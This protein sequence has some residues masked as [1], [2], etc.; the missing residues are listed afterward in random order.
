[1]LKC[2][3]NAQEKLTHPPQFQVP[4]DLCPQKLKTHNPGISSGSSVVCL[5]AVHSLQPSPDTSTT[6]Q[7]HALASVRWTSGV[8]RHA[9]LQVCPFLNYF[10]TGVMS[11]CQLLM[12]HN[13]IMPQIWE[14][15]NMMGVLPFAI[16]WTHKAVV[17]LCNQYEV[18]V[19]PCYWE[20]SLKSSTNYC[21]WTE[22]SGAAKAEATTLGSPS[23]IIVMVSVYLKQHLKK[24]NWQWSYVTVWPLLT[25]DCDAI[26]Q[27]REFHL[28]EGQS[29]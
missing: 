3:A 20:R 21:H 23:L 2:V 10:L 15:W 6:D 28:H 29:F 25:N 24:K 18:S 22:S 14:W 7:Q 27:L 11:A 8:C 16:T 9:K 1:M 5:A 4:R 13:I 17:K 26:Q 19:D 12:L